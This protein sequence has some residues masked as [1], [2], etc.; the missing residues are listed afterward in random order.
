MVKASSSSKA[1]KVSVQGNN[2]TTSVTVPSKDAIKYTQVQSNSASLFAQQAKTSATDA[3]RNA[4]RA[5]VWAEGS[6][7]EVAAL[8]GEHSSKGWV[9]QAKNYTKEV[10]NIQDALLSNTAVTTVFNHMEALLDLKESKDELIEIRDDVE[11]AA[12]TTTEQADRAER[13][14]E[15]ISQFAE[16]TQ[17]NA[18]MAAVSAGMASNHLKDATKQANIAITNSEIAITNA[19]IASTQ[20]SNALSSAKNSKTS[21]TNA[22]TY[23]NNANASAITAKEKAQESADY[24]ELSKQ[25][26]ISETLVDNTDYSSKHYAN[27]AK[28]E[29]T[30]AESYRGQVSQHAEDAQ[31][32]ANMASASSR[33]A[34][35]YLEATTEQANISTTNAEI[36]ITQ[37]GNALKSAENAALSEANAKES[38]NKAKVSEQNA[39]SSEQ[40]CEEIYARLGIVIIVKGRVDSLE[41]LPTTDVVNGDAYLVGVD[42]LDSYPEYYWYEDHWEYM[43]STDVKLEWGNVSGTLSNQTDLQAVLDKKLENQS[44]FKDALSIGKDNIDGGLATT[45]GFRND[46]VYSSYGVLMGYDNYANGTNNVCIG[47]WC[48]ASGDNSICIGSFIIYDFVFNNFFFK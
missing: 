33:S 32:Y 48:E 6:D 15:Q 44:R 5:K 18:N 3:A 28:E 47:K 42:G 27:I 9:E 25:W 26:A 16:E 40:R 46:A 30:K 8:G 12:Q 29:A 24:S 39:K 22:L 17:H 13:Y 14:A 19:E 38:E 41:D 31:Y 21:E 45:I 37:A 36:S 7:T 34:Y 23:S 1:T 20:A 10:Q 35:E 2:S 43:G 11:T 4:N